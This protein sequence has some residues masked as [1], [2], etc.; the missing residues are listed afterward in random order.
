LLSDLHV[1]EPELS[2]RELRSEVRTD[3]IVLD[4]GRVQPEEIGELG[5]QRL[6]D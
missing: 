4:G 6:L 1:G 2:E 5:P 3:M